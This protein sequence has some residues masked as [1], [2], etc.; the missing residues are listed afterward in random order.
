[1]SNGKVRKLNEGRGL[2]DYL[3][4]A[5]PVVLFLVLL[6]M[7][8]DFYYDLNDDATIRNI[9]SGA[10]TGT[11]EAHAVYIKYPLGLFLSLLYRIAP[12]F[13]W[14]GVFEIL[15]IL[16]SLYF[17]SVAFSSLSD[18]IY[19]KFILSFGATALAGTLIV[20]ETVFIQ[21]TVVSGL[22]AAAGVVWIVTDKKRKLDIANIVIAAILFTLSFLVRSNM[23]L[24]M[25]PFIGVALV[26]SVIK[27]LGDERAN[28][29]KK[30]SKTEEN[31][32]NI[33][34]NK[35]ESKEEKKLV[36]NTD[37]N[38]LIVKYALYVVPA[39]VLI[40]LMQLIDTVAYS[41]NSWKNY[42]EWN[43][44]RTVLFD[45]QKDAPWYEFHPDFYENIGFSEAQ[46]DIL[47][48][49]N[50]AFTSDIT[51]DI[52]KKTVEYNIV[53]VGHGF[54]ETGFK[55]AVTFYIY[56]LHKTKECRFS[57]F[58]IAMYVI[59]IIACIITKKFPYATFALIMFAA[60][61]VDWMYLI[62]RGRIKDRVTVP[63]C[64]IEI[65]LLFS[66]T[67]ALMYKNKWQSGLIIG[68]ILITLAFS[69]FVLRTNVEL[70]NNEANARIEKDAGWES[71]RHYFGE[72]PDSFY[73]IDLLSNADYSE[74]IFSN[75]ESA[76]RNYELCGGWIAASPV[77][78]K[79]LEKAGITAVDQALLENENVYFVASD[80]R[81]LN[82]IDEY[83]K[84]KGINVKREI[85]DTVTLNEEESYVIYSVSACDSEE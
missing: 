73:F 67:I 45:Y 54:F 80:S 2:Y 46:A 30:E 6:S 16:A 37:V 32:E 52:L 84:V 35:Q 33:N 28:D 43:E 9:L 85:V 12:A 29:N 31:K 47:V 25:T 22:L 70:T 55:D 61:T 50:I 64:V 38:N 68:T 21:Y 24:F 20:Y 81:D 60:R 42:K 44:Y 26:F 10:F 14:F 75:D 72:H 62:L 1:M 78:D 77:Y 57:L 82:W 17:I 66:L 41:S 8:W 79:K 15:A 11:P 83:Y 48:D 7:A 36:N 39:I 49:T 5:L 18:Y 34:V 63:L 59:F 4:S 69:R 58:I 23:F 53:S 65:L 13:H 56:T 27:G 74:K 3:I 40:F 76:F 71:V 19:V 51:T